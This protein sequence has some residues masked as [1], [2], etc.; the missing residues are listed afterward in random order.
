[1]SRGLRA[2]AWGASSLTLP[3]LVQDAV[4]ASL[5]NEEGHTTTVE[6]LAAGYHLLIR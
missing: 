2:P 4:D 5:G 1:M 3:G 6:G